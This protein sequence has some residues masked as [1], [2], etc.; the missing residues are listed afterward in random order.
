MTSLVL[1][2]QKDAL[3]KNI[4]ISDLLRKGLVLAKKLKIKEFETW[5]I[6][7]LNG[8]TK[9]TDI[10][11]YREVRGEPK[12]YNPYRGYIP[13]VFNDSKTADLFCVN[14]IS[15]PIAEVEDMARDAGKGSTL[16]M[17]Y[18]PEI[19]TSLMRATGNNFSSALIIPAIRAIGI[20]DAVRT[21]IL[22]WTLKL[23]EEG[24]LGEGFSFTPEEIKKATNTSHNINN[25]YGTINQANIQQDN[26]RAIQKPKV[27]ID[28][29][30]VINFLDELDSVKNKLELK[31]E[32]KA[33]LISDLNSVRSQVKSP[34]PKMSIIELGLSSIKNILEGAGGVIVAQLLAT[35]A[36]CNT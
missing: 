32:V 11:K 36:G 18:S 9:R 1:E 12:A 13:I 24:I 25:F 21:V 28:C 22:D 23:E 27:N 6:K 7:E 30:K 31:K 5:V 10:P 8:Y 3:D 16:T 29:D 33:E 34:N 17:P 20:V 15:Q 4:N 35:L 2:I 19:Q 26:K 14:K